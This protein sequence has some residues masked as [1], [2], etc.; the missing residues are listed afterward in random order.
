MDSSTESTSPGP[1][2]DPESANR[3]THAIYGLQLATLITGITLFVAVIINYLKREEVA[4]TIYEAHF[5]WQIRTFWVLVILYAVAI[6][7]FLIAAMIVGFTGG[8]HETGMMGMPLGFGFLV[9]P[10]IGLISVVY[11][12]YRVA[13]GWI[14]LNENRMPPGVEEEN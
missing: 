6:G 2:M 7:L 10:L 1:T 4:G 14:C 13:R 3:L 11:L 8:R 9:F 5:R 12:I